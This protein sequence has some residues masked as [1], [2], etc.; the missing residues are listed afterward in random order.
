MNASKQSQAL[1]RTA[2]RIGFVLSLLLLIA[3]AVA[4]YYATLAVQKGRRE[5]AASVNVTITGQACEPNEITVS[6]GRNI[7]RIA[8]RSDRA[9]EWEI[10]DGVMVLEE[11]ENIAPGFTQA[12]TTRLEPGDYAITC[13]LISNPRGKLH[14]QPAANAGPAAKPNLTAFI[15]ALAEYKVFLATETDAFVDAATAFAN[16]V[17]SGD[18]AAAKAAYLPAETAYARIAPVSPLF[19]DL[20]TAIDGRADGF[21][22]READPAFGGLHRLEY[23]LFRQGSLEGLA[24]VADRLA[25]DA[26]TLKARIHDLRIM[27]ESMVGGAAAILERVAAAG[28]GFGDSP[29]AHADLAS[30]EATV[31]GVRKVFDLLRPVAARSAPAIAASI[32][33]DFAALDKSIAAR[34]AEVTE[35]LADPAKAELGK[36]ATALAAD[37]SRLRDM[38]DLSQ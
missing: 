9:V 23:G 38:M 18:L 16:A 37:L 15:G 17:K 31:S 3:S 12:L 28:P 1:P 7:F 29:Y 30:F 33:A 11:R 8:N 19:S 10:L 13:G 35:A 24:P 26:A 21:G 36:A 6:A 5:A 4:F 27:P 2:V 32:D 22:Q 34:R 14:V 25:A 20:D